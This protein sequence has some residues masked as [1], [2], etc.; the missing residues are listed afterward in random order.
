MPLQLSGWS[1]P[2][3]GSAYDPP[4]PVLSPKAAGELV[5]CAETFH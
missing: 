5:L 2:Q 1:V 3:A 4:Q